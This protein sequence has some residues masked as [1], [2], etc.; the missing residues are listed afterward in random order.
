MTI[1]VLTVE[2]LKNSRSYR[3]YLTRMFGILWKL[4]YFGVLRFLFEVSRRLVNF[5]YKVCFITSHGSVICAAAIAG[6]IHGHFILLQNKQAFNHSFS[7]QLLSLQ[8]NAPRL[9]DSRYHGKINIQRLIF[10]HGYTFVTAFW[11]W[12]RDYAIHVPPLYSTEAHK[13]GDITGSPHW[14]LNIG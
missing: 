3:R 2:F 1:I 9:P 13:A 10:F 6:S 14:R 7:L 8:C 4:D 5:Q 11:G 12:R